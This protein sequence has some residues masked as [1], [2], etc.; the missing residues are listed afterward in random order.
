M[1]YRRLYQA[2]SRAVKILHRYNLTLRHYPSE[3]PKT[4]TPIERD[5]CILAH[6]E[7]NARGRIKGLLIDVRA[8]RESLGLNS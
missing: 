5:L 6:S 8:Y 7:S 1:G 3:Y 2:R 4:M